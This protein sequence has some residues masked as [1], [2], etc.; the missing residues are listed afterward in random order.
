MR[1]RSD[2][3][4]GFVGRRQGALLGLI[5]AA[6]GKPIYRGVAMDEPVEDMVE[7]EVD[8]L[9]AAEQTGDPIGHSRLRLSRGR[10]SARVSARVR[11]PCWL[12][13]G[14]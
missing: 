10:R 1:L 12:L 4:D 9:E 6:T 11:R 5:E 2:D 13:R 8:G 7:N 14:P 3:F